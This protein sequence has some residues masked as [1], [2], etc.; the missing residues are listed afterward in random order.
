MCYKKPGP[1]CSSHARKEC[2]AAR[3]HWLALRERFGIDSPQAQEAFDIYMQKRDIFDSTPQGQKILSRKMHELRTEDVSGFR[4]RK[5]RAEVSDELARLEERRR[6]G[7]D[8]RIMQM[9]QYH[10]LQAERAAR[11]EKISTGLDERWGTAHKLDASWTTAGGDEIRVFEK[12]SSDHYF[13]QNKHKHQRV[14]WRIRN[15]E[16]VAMVT[17]TLPAEGMYDQNVIGE[18]EVNPVYR[19]QELG[20]DTVREVGLK[21]GTLY[22]SGSFSQSGSRSLGGKSPKIP[23]YPE[24]VSNTV[25]HFEFVDWD[26]GTMLEEFLN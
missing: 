8:M 4:N 10:S 9:K 15:G 7:A 1:R 12:A 14:A 18:V 3:D 11:G 2:V 16:P 19:G 13:A 25:S 24:Y 23:G 21:Y 5:R 20:A 26:A 6:R 22:S 17:F